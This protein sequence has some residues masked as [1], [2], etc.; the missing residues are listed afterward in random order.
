MWFKFY[1]PLNNRITIFGTLS[2]K[3]SYPPI[4]NYSHY[5]V[6]IYK[7]YYISIL[8]LFILILKSYPLSVY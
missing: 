1:Q 2:N 6:S 4:F 3:K 7:S 8:S 5:C